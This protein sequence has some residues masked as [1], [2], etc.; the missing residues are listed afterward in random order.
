ML[1]E[2]K[3]MARPPKPGPCIHCL[4]DFDSLNWDHVFPQAW[5]PDSTPNGLEKWK[6]PTCYKCNK[7]YGVIE[8]DLLVRIGICLDID[9]PDTSS[10]AQKA[11][12]SVNP[13]RAKNSKDRKAR[14]ALKRKIT[15]NL[16]DPSVVPKESIYPEFGP[17]K[18]VEQTAGITLPKIGLERLAEKIVRGISYIED[19]LLIRPPYEVSVYIMHDISAFPIIQ[20]LRDHGTIHER[21]PGIEVVRA[22]LPEDSSIGL[23]SITIWKKFKIYAFVGPPDIELRS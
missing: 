16:I 7:E 6:I 15:S 19:G 4:K 13:D 2:S 22:V 20:L 14:K 9:D 5:Y 8:K 10:I 21:E 1:G 23:F 18:A 17:E 12:N 3:P 11:L